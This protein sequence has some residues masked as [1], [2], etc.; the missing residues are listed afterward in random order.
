MPSQYGFQI[1]APAR[2]ALTDQFRTSENPLHHLRLLRA[3]QRL[4][5]QV[6]LEDGAI[7]VDELDDGGRFKMRGDEES[8]HLVLLDSDQQVI[9]GARYLL[10]SNTADF[11][12][13]RLSEC[14]L[15]KNPQ[16]ATTLRA[17]I[18]RDMQ[19]ARSRNHVYIE[20]GGWVL[21][22]E[23]RCSRAALEIAVGSFA[24]GALWGGAVGA[25]TATYRH[26]S[27][28]ILSRLGGGCL[29]VDG[30][31]VPSYF[32]PQYGCTMEILRFDSLYPEKRFEILLKHLTR[33]L[34]TS[35]LTVASV[36]RKPLPG[37]VMPAVSPAFA[38][39]CTIDSLTNEATCQPR[40]L[41]HSTVGGLVP[42]PP[43]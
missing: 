14:A 10:H 30:V 11:E 25:C 13:L 35:P 19:L 40:L 36:T 41:H 23:W 26:G 42:G 5:G 18:E 6:Y 21:S 8:W 29:Q 15:A 3:V 9:G 28:S 17:A 43:A 20:I 22:K 27:A 12:S 38:L 2:S 32:D 7:K 16:W 34:S 37:L 33:A 31:A 4:R 1:L 24:L 39:S